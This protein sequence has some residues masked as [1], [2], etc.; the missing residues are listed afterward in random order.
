MRAGVDIGGESGLDPVEL[1]AGVDA[2]VL[3][4]GALE[5]RELDVPGRDLD[6][7]HQAMDYL[8]LANRVRTGEL[9]D[10]ARSTRPASRS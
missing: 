4:T 1:R 2:V 5:A 6:G 7:V 9:P 10:A 8:P 3:A